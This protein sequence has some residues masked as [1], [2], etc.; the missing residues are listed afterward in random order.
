MVSVPY[1]IRP[2][3]GVNMVST[4]CGYCPD[5]TYPLWS[6]DLEQLHGS[7]LSVIYL[8]LG[9]SMSLGSR[10]VSYLKVTI[11]SGF[12]LSV[13]SLN[14]NPKISVCIIQRI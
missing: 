12:Y 4:D 13:Q 10:Y 5:N 7:S 9:N 8:C 14:C 3:Y 11:T 1:L 6:V 2:K